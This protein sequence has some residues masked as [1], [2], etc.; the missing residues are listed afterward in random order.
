[1]SFENGMAAI[2]LEM[3]D[4]VPRTEY[5][6]DSHW[7][8]VE[9]VTGLAASDTDPAE[10]REA[11]SGAFVRAWDYG[12]YWNILT[13]SNIFGDKRTKMGHAVYNAGGTDFSTE[14]SC[15][16]DD[17]EDVYDYD[18][19][20]A[21][22]SRDK[23][24]LTG[25]FNDDYDR[26]RRLWTDA[27]P[28]TGVY[29]TCM[30][31]LL[32]L[33]GWDIL[34]EAAGIDNAAFGAFTDRYCKW[35]SQYFEALA[36]SRCPVVMVHDDIVWGTGAFLH[37][38]FYRKYIFPN[39]KM[40]FEPLHDAGKIILYTSD[41]NYTEFID[42]IAAC[43]VRGFVMEPGTDMAYVADKYGKTHVFIGNADTN[44]LLRGTRDDIEAEVRRCMDIGKRHPGFI[45]SVGNHIPPNTPVDNALW[46]D[47]A[48]R[49][50]SKR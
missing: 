18:M 6:A 28:M 45:L 27:V 19:F 26:H 31:G 50:L 46:Y 35:I 34:L 40:L 32:E 1:M 42:D 15:L 2:R 9:R 43:G 4:A 47:E 39:Y 37:P 8:L 38:D 3:P 24:V 49:R 30:S 44:V 14:V 36:D 41:G 11:A 25:E 13:H 33:L 16:F 12:M 17:P 22:G 21:Y 23:A 5:S 48:Y 20:D 10:V 7:E 29:V